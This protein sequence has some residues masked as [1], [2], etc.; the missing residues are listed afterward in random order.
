MKFIHTADVHL[1]SPLAG[2]SRY[3]GFPADVFRTATRRAFDRLIEDAIAE[4]VNFVVIAGDL[5]DGDWR[6]MNTGLYFLSRCNDLARHNIHVILLYG[7]HDAEKEMTRRLVP[8]ANVHLFPSNK[9]HTFR[10]DDLGVAFHGWS[11]KHKVTTDNLAREYPKPIVGM[12]NIAVLHTALEGHTEHAAYAPCTVNQLREAGMDYWALGHV[13]EAKNHCVD[14]W[15]VYPGNLQGRSVRETG[16]RGAVLVEL[17]NDKLQVEQRS[18]DVVRWAHERID[19]TG[20]QDFPAATGRI[21]S[22]LRAVAENHP[23]LP[24]AIRLTLVG[25]TPIHTELLNRGKADLRAEALV[26]AKA[27]SADFWVEKVRIET[28]PSTSDSQLRERSDALGDLEALLAK[29]VDDADFMATLQKEYQMVIDKVH[30][31]ILGEVAVLAAIR[32]GKLASAIQEV[33]PALIDLVGQEI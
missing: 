29:A 16:P 33:S 13:H 11:F 1:D 7:N 5:Y 31:S 9:P 28:A 4:K 27:A 21:T 8:P 25:S 23:D 3:E 32:D 14:P 15:I 26:A 20:I 2:L 6:D 10:F 12:L 22:H 17:V 19:L 18:Y 30:P 24:L